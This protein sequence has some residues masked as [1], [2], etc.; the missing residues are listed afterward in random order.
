MIHLNHLYAV[1]EHHDAMAL[2][3]LDKRAGSII[4]TI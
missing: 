2:T 3:S 1:R 4:P